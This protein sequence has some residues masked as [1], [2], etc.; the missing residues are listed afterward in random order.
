MRRRERDHVHDVLTWDEFVAALL[1]A[2][3]DPGHWFWDW[4]DARPALR[5]HVHGW[6]LAWFSETVPDAA[7]MTPDMLAG[8][9]EALESLTRGEGEGP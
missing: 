8:Y 2:R 7:D 3:D 5:D 6:F 4:M 1:A 9:T